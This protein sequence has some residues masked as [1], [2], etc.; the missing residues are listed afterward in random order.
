MLNVDEYH[1]GLDI[2]ADEGADVY[3]VR[4]GTVT[5]IRTSETYGN[6]M[7][8]ETNDGYR[9]VYCHLQKILAEEG[10][11]I[12]QGEVVA[13]AG[14]TG[15]VTG[16]HLHYTVYLGSMLMDPLQFTSYRA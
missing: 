1:N 12:V 4:S 15:L 14:S 8:F 9:I 10:E 6:V 11:K 3:A 5:D 2:A 13:L 16:P 7:E